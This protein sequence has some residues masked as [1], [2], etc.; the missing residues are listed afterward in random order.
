MLKSVE[1]PLRLAI[2]LV[3]GLASITARAE[4]GETIYLVRH[5]EKIS[6]APDALLNSVGHERANCLARTLA[7]AH[8]QAIFTTQVQRTQQTARPLAKKLGLQSVV[9][10]ANDIMTL[11]GKIKEKHGN[12]LVIGHSDTLPELIETLSSQNVDIAKAAY[13][14]LFLLHRTGNKMELV[15]LHYCPCR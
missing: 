12:I 6:D 13:D 10:T 1:R 2:L 15:V 11:A 3:L 14:Q 4:D 5:A 9:T 8:I 7:D